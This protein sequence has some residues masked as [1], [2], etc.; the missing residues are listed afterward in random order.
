MKKIVLI[1]NL[2]MST[3]LLVTKMRNAAKEEGIECDINAY[4]M[5]DAAKHQDAD[6]VLL[7]PQIQYALNNLRTKLP[8]TKVEPIDMKAY[9][10]VDGKKVLKE[11]LLKIGE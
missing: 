10:M 9:G 7:G 5:S 8:N 3:S 6:I 1:C 4:P 2:G 11:A